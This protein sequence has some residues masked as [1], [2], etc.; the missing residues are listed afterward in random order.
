MTLIIG[1]GP[2]G[3]ATSRELARAG[4]DHVVLER[5]RRAGQTWADLYD[6]L[7]LHTAR[8]LSALPGL[9]F[10]RG[11]PRFP[12]R[13]VFVQ[14]LEEYAATFRS[15]VRTSTEVATLRRDDG[16]WLAQTVAGETFSAES[17]IVATGIV[18]NPWSPDIPYRHRF[19]GRVLHSVEYRRPDTLARQR[20]LVVGCGNSAGE[21]AVE[22]AAAGA[23]VTVSVRSGGAAVPRELFGVPIQ[24]F[25]VAVGFLPKAG[26][27]TA[28]AILSRINRVSHGPSVLP[29]PQPAGCPRV[30][31]I[32]FHLVDAIR[33]GVI[34]LK[35]ELKEFTSHGMRFGDGSSQAFDAVLFATGYR[36]AVGMLDGV[37]RLDECG[38]ARRHDRVTSADQPGLYFV[39]HN[40]DIRGGLF[41]IGR[42]ARCAARRITAERRDTSRTAT[43]MRPRTN[44]R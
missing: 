40:Y 4:V 37:I 39:G 26:Q 19:D 16:R 32:G 42:D 18:A 9:P 21:I 5:G 33:D 2:A 30:P 20:V 3:L 15:P 31:L 35:G 36:A 13:T 41:N 12:S 7:V 14:Y 34:R 11:T 1:A 28:A 24:Y 38:F 8:E 25:S 23:T 29:P 44:E 27:R 43:E 6:S 10:P 22:L 17:A